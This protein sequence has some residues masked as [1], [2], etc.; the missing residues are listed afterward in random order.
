MSNIPD[1]PCGHSSLFGAEAVAVEPD[2]WWGPDGIDALLWADPPPYAEPVPEP[3]AS[4][5]PLWAGDA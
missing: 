3:A 5:A 4:A 1:N 2:V